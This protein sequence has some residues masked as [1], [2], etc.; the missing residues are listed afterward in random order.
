MVERSGDS[1]IDCSCDDDRATGDGHSSGISAP[2]LALRKSPLWVEILTC[3]PDPPGDHWNRGAREL[4][5]IL[6]AEE[7]PQLATYSSS[8]DG[9]C[10]GKVG[11][12]LQ[13]LRLLMM[14][15]LIGV[16]VSHK[17]PIATP[18]SPCRSENSEKGVFGFM[19][20][21]KQLSCIGTIAAPLA[22]PRYSVENE[23]RQRRRQVA[24][25]R[26]QFA[27][28]RRLGFIWRNC[29]PLNPLVPQK[30][31]KLFHRPPFGL[32]TNAAAKSPRRLPSPAP[33]QRAGRGRR[34]RTRGSR[35]GAGHADESASAAACAVPV[36]EGEQQRED[37]ELGCCGF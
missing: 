19:H 2:Q 9:K 37:S 6:L 35:H 36:S 1:T 30:I 33:P 12:P 17:I 21:S 24:Q 18:S 10:H 16:A 27:T 15:A 25:A 29:S 34:C 3:P 32:R 20:L 26:S 31:H 28:P 4:K 5:L 14:S 8:L 11:Q 13:G 22:T 23:G 7:D